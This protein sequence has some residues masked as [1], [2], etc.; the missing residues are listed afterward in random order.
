M[1]PARVSGDYRAATG[2][3]ASESRR[4]LVSDRKV[5]VR[6]TRRGLA[7][8]VIPAMPYGRVVLELHLR[9]RFGWWPSARRR[10]DYLS[11]ASFRVPRRIAARVALVTSDG[12]THLATSR[13]VGL[14]P[15]PTSHLPSAHTHG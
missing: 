3:G 10:L 8:T 13:V 2:A 7:V 12:W 4:L 1:L 5:I 14:T 9:D 6:R 11:E 15:G